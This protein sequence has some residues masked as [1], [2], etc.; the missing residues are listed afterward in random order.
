M[1]KAAFDQTKAD[2]CEIGQLAEELADAFEAV[3]TAKEFK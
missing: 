1:K 3:K 2:A